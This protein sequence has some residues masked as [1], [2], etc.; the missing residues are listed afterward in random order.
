MNLDEKRKPSEIK[1]RIKE[2][3]PMG[4]LLRDLSFENITKFGVRFQDTT[5]LDINDCIP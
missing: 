1:P 5:W 3:P 4:G 2:V